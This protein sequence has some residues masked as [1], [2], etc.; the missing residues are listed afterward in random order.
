MAAKKRFNFKS[1]HKSPSGGLNARGQSCVQPR[2]WI[3]PE[4]P[5]A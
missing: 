4:G 2:N 5:A 3:E 1:E